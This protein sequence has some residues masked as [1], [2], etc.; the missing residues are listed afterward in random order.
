MD[1]RKKYHKYTH[2][3]R[4]IIP[5]GKS[6]FLQFFYIYNP[7]RYLHSYLSW[8]SHIEISKYNCSWIEEIRI[9]TKTKKRKK[10]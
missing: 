4:V 7:I 10:L 1:L 9:E 8:K 6:K 5:Y 2:D 3:G